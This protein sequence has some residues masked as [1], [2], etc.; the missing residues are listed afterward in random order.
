MAYGGAGGM[1]AIPT[2][3][4]LGITRVVVPRF[5]G[6][7]SALGVAASDIKHDAVRTHL[8]RLTAGTLDRVRAL[9]REL[10][11]DA[12]RQLEQDG[13]KPADTRA[14]FALD[15]RYAGQAFE[16]TLPVEP[17][18]MAVPEVARAFHAAHRQTYGHANES[19][20]VE[21]VNV[22]L[23]AYG[24]VAKPELARHRSESQRLDEA[25]VE[26]RPVWLEDGFRPCPVYERERL[27]ERAELAGPAIVEEFGATTVVFPG[28]RGWLDDVGNLRLERV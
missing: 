23:T 18:A 25:L 13:F 28:W 10:A 22:R 3:E 21:V 9:A 24:V 2:A 20:A 8:A 16:L 14:A 6:N 12:A 7:F 26:T 15:L 5:P 27:P 17:D 1:H 11:A 4:E 19:G